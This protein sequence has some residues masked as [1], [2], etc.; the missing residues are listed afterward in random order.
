MLLCVYV[1][2]YTHACDICFCVHAVYMF[3]CAGVFIH[4]DI[5]RGQCLLSGCLSQCL[6]SMYF[7]TRSLI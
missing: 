3:V 6:S 5:C 4:V 1:C 7:K 2:E